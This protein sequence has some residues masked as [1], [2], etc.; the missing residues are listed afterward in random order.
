M[1][2][3]D[4]PSFFICPISLEIMKDPV[5]VST[6]I[7][8]DRES[9][10]KWMFSGKNTTCPV[11]KQVISDCEITPNH[12]L[13]RLIQSWCMLNASHG[14]ERIPTPKPP[15]SK[16][17]IIKLIND[18]KS[19]QQQIKCL[20]S[21]QSIAS[22]NSTNKRCIES[23]GA[24]DFLVSIVNNSDS[25]ASLVAEALSILYN[26]QLTEASLKNLMCK[27]SD[28]I[29][30]L[31]RVMQ[32]GSY[33]SRAYAVLLSKSMVE[34]ADPMKL[35]NLRPELFVE[36][37]QVLRDQ[38]SKQASKASLQ[39]LATICPWGR[40]KVK[41]AEAGVVPVIIDML[42][43]SSLERRACEMV[44]IVLDAVCKCAEGRS[45]L[46][47]HGAGL[48]VVSKKILRVS[49]VASERAVRILLSISKF[50]ATTKVLQEMLQLGVVAKLCLVLQVDCGFKTKERAREV[51][52]LHARVWKNSPCIPSNLISS[53]P[54]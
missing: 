48:V 18:A 39:L 50:C 15:I 22:E 1:D 16:A 9:I 4:V 12:T 31:T 41:A 43:D 2:D 23:S 17:Q 20:K 36:S 32:R 13:R 35:I 54:A 52:K 19:P 30:C 27:N 6:G 26:L 3:I 45:E 42:L 8:Y 29:R 7:T 14:I 25:S 34:V 37:I 51:L 46:L 53:Y 47:L 5:T 49:Q 24:V 10:E 21:L 44:L 40:N 38:I 28:F 33:E 11:T